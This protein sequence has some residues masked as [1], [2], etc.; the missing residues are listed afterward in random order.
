MEEFHVLGHAACFKM[1]IVC[2]DIQIILYKTDV[3]T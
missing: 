2:Y 3:F 1:W